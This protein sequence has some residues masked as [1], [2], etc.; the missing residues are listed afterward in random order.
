VVGNDTNFSFGSSQQHR[1]RFSTTGNDTLQIGV[2]PNA[3]NSAALA[4]VHSS[5]LGAANRSP[6]TLHTDPTLYIYSTDIGQANDYIRIYHNQSDAMIEVGNGGIQFSSP[7]LVAYSIAGNN[8]LNVASD[9][10]YVNI[11]TG[12]E[13]FAVNSAY[14]GDETFV[15]GYHPVS[16]VEQV[17]V[18]YIPLGLVNG[19]WLCVGNYAGNNPLEV[20]PA[21]S[22]NLPAVRIDQTNNDAFAFIRY[23]GVSASNLTKNITTKTTGMTLNGFVRVNV[24]GSDKWMPF[25]IE[26][27]VP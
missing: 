24:N 21:S 9:V 5:H 2:T 3:S 11:G 15:A 16:A 20:I 22:T 12:A 8:I 4:L 6:T 27:I 10:A 19:S 18:N 7:S 13:R 26:E 17:L 1:I 25:Y 14:F 23:E